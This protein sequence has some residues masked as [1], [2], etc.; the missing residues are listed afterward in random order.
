MRLITILAGL[1]LC[2]VFGI[3]AVLNSVLFSMPMD[4]NLALESLKAELRSSANL[5]TNWRITLEPTKVIARNG[6]LIFS[7]EGAAERPL[8]SQVENLPIVE[9]LK[10]DFIGIV[11]REC[12]QQNTSCYK[13]EDI[14]VSAE[15]SL[16][17]II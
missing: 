3:L 1:T 4:D 2:L 6:E 11:T 5:G 15:K 9:R 10:F 14:G 13:T 7:G 8:V 16:Q 12:H 17:P